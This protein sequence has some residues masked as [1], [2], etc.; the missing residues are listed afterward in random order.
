MIR[1]GSE[2]ER[3]KIEH[4]TPSQ[5][6]D[7]FQNNKAPAG[8][9]VT[10]RRSQNGGVILHIASRE[11]KKVIEGDA[12]AIRRNCPSAHV[13]K[14]AFVVAVDSVRVDAFDNKD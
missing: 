11:A 3:K 14:P 5:L 10:V 1:I 12:E 13:L 7:I 2:E 4:A 6:K 8:S 9:I